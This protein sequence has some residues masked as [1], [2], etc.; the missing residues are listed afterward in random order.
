MQKAKERQNQSQF[1]DYQKQGRAGLGPFTSHIWR[2]DPQHLGFL[3]ARYKFCAKMLADKQQVLEVGCGD[4]FGT[5]VMLQ[6]VKSIHG[7]D[8]E[9]LVI[10]AAKKRLADEGVKDLKLSVLDITERPTEETFDAAYSLDVI[11]HIK[12]ELEH[13]FIGNICRSLKGNAV[14]VIGTPNIAASGYATGA[15][16]EGHINLKGHKELK[17][18]VSEF[19]KNVF[20]FSMNDEVVHTGYYPMAHYLLAVGAGLREDIDHAGA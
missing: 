19:F 10:D 12:P 2:T 1:D 4:A 5:M 15:S 13:A 16:K 18:L 8:F 17:E 11:E 14:C 3:L 9:P 20:L 7:I 6:Y